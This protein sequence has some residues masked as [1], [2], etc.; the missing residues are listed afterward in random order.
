ML[1]QQFITPSLM[2]AAID[3]Q[4]ADLTGD[5]A[6]IADCKC[7]EQPLAGSQ[8]VADYGHAVLT[9]SV[10]CLEQKRAEL[11]RRIGAQ[12]AE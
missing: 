6:R 9:A 3:K 5:L 4:I 12:A 10:N 2:L 11:V 8:F 1:L 7:S